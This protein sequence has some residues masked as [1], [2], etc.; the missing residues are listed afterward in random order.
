MP[1][2]SHRKIFP[3]SK[4]KRTNRRRWPNRKQ[5]RRFIVFQLINCELARAIAQ[6]MDVKRIMECY[7]ILFL[8]WILSSQTRVE[9]MRFWKFHMA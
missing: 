3:P 8:Q 4:A 7:N 2:R 6:L 5:A 9:I 1:H